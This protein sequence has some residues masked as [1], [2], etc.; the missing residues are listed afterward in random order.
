[1][2]AQDRLNLGTSLGL[3]VGWAGLWTRQPACLSQNGNSNVFHPLFPCISDSISTFASGKC[4]PYP[5]AVKDTLDFEGHAGHAQSNVH[6]GKSVPFLN[7]RVEKVT[8]RKLQESFA[9]CI[10]IPFFGGSIPL[11]SSPWRSDAIDGLLPPE[12]TRQFECYTA[13][14]CSVPIGQSRP[15]ITMVG[16]WVATGIT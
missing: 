15:R 5:L 3:A 7:K 13:L 4:V 6:I 9:L 8:S 10:S 1:M 16:F 2:L 12:S 11:A 14:V